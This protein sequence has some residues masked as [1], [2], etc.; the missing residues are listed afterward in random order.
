MALETVVAQI[1]HEA[2]FASK[3]ETSMLP[4]CCLCGLIRD[5]GGVPLDRERWITRRAYLKTHG[6]NPADC[7]LA[8]TYCPSCFT[9]GM[10]T[11]RQHELENR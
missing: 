2:P 3:K 4:I 1:T 7:V 6:V 10:E 9:E 11:T 8:H 5:K